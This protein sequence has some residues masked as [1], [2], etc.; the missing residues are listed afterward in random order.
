MGFAPPEDAPPP[1]E[2]SAVQADVGFAPSPTGASIC[3]FGFP[4]FV[5]SLAFFIPGFPPF[6]FP[7]TFNFM[8]GLNCDL[9]N[10]ISASVSFGG[11]R[12]SNTNPEADPEFG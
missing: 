8:L 2:Q 10:P 12:V 9:S 1:E 4:S 5:F 11:G 6:A 3:G 7:P